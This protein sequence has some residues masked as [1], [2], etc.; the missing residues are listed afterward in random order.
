MQNSMASAL[1]LTAASPRASLH[2]LQQ[3]PSASL[4]LPLVWAASVMP[5]SPG[6]ARRSYQ[7]SIGCC[8]V[9]AAAGLQEGQAWRR[10]V[11]TTASWGFPGSLRIVPQ[12]AL[13]TVGWSSWCTL[14]SSAAT[15]RLYRSSSLRHTPRCPMR[16]SVQLTT[17]LC[18]HQAELAAPRGAGGPRMCLL[19]PKLSSSTRRSA[20]DASNASMLPL[21]PSRS[22]VAKVAQESSCSTAIA[23]KTLS[24]PWRDVLRVQFPS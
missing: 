23:R 22:M 1:T 9:L 20:R 7:D 12:S 11:T 6:C 13:P 19:D 18:E 5:L 3:E 4:G 10:R 24:Q 8:A 17:S 2:C 14:M 15:P 16:I 21:R